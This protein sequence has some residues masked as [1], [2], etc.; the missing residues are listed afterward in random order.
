MTGVV[1]RYGANE[2]LTFG[3]FVFDALP[4]PRDEKK[5]AV[6]PSYVGDMGTDGHTE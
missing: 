4:S 3:A 6:V 1:R 5:G 2:S